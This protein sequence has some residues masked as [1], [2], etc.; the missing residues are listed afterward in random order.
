[1][2]GMWRKTHMPHRISQ[3]KTKQTKKATAPTNSHVKILKPIHP[4][5]E[6][7]Q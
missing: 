6:K 1:M 2:L 4:H 3:R 5:K 7:K